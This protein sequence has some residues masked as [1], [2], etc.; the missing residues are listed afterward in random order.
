VRSGADARSLALDPQQDDWQ[1]PA[2][3]PLETIAPAGVNT[4]GPA[5]GGQR[6][7]AIALG[8]IVSLGFMLRL[9]GATQLSPHVDEPASLLA[10]HAAVERGLPILPSGTPYFQGVTLSYLLS[11]FIWL[12]LGDLEYLAIMRLVLVVAGTLAIFLSY[13]LARYATGNPWIGAT[14][15]ALVAIDPVSVQWSSHVRMYALLQS[16]T[17]G[18]AW[19]FIHLLVRGPS[20]LRVAAVVALFWLAVF[21]HV[22]ATLLLPAMLLTVLV[23]ARRTFVPRRGFLALFTLCDIAP[24]LLLLLNRMFGVK[25][26]DVGESSREPAISFVGD[27]LIAPLSRFQVSPADWE[28]DALVQA[29]ALFWLIP[30]LIV[31]ICSLVVARRCLLINSCA[32]APA[33]L[34]GCMVCFIMYW[35]PVLT[36]AV[37]TASP[38]PRYLLHVHTLGYLFVAVLLCGLTRTQW[39][40]RTGLRNAVGPLLACGAIVVVLTGIGGG[41]VWRL[42]HLVVHPDYHAAMAYAA[43]NHSPR[44]PVI[45]ALP[46]VAYLAM[47]GSDRDD[48]YFLA[49]SR[50]STRADRYTLA[51][52]DGK[53]VDYWVGIDSIVT[54]EELRNLLVEN[55]NSLLV[56]DEYRLEADWAYRGEI[57]DVIREMTRVVYRAQG[58]ALVLMPYK[59]VK[60][61]AEDKGLRLP[62]GGEQGHRGVGS[63]C[64]PERSSRVGGGRA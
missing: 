35:L 61:I 20:K 43:A 58:G 38:K 10:A 14:M 29:S 54:V 53:S 36:V 60:S 41:L 12:G 33:T 8:T 26:V 4:L 62:S 23:L 50:E 2:V 57:E 42:Q 22:G 15:A 31:A 16:L 34:I 59:G 51:T 40:E 32:A 3:G 11:P 37:L 17:V 55:P 30:G 48:L 45:V 18:L 46:P 1:D 49:G 28:L 52:E 21:T 13:G 24:L 44:Q 64:M 5:R 7:V 56:I 63:L 9:Y 6:A 25:S 47:D 19:A 27:N 39:K